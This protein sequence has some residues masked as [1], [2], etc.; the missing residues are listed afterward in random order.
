MAESIPEGINQKHIEGAIAALDAGEEHKFAPSVGY[1]LIF[2]GKAYAPKAV[3][4]M[5]VYLS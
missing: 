4:G 5:A 2:R 3:L 1:D